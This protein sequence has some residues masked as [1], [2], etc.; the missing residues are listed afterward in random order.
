MYKRKL[1]KVNQWI[2]GSRDCSKVTLET[3]KNMCFGSNY[4][5][6]NWFNNEVSLTQVNVACVLKFATLF[7]E[8]VKLEWLLVRQQPQRRLKKTMF[9]SDGWLHLCC[10]PVHCVGRPCEAP[11][12][13]RELLWHHCHPLLHH[14][15]KRI[16][17]GEG[18]EHSTYCVYVFF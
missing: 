12:I 17:K 11:W 7:S 9:R 3:V 1:H 4:Q 15:W 18:M 10:Q 16:G 2:D 6:L 13:P 14:V 8:L 5:T